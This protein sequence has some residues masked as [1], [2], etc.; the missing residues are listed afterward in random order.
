MGHA[1]LVRAFEQLGLEIVHAVVETPNVA[2]Q[3]VARKIGMRH[4]G[5]TT[6]FYDAELE[7][8]T[9]TRDEWRATRSGV[10]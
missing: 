6:A 8:F 4:A 1:L 9:L 5:R 10:G 2:S 7:H 3:R